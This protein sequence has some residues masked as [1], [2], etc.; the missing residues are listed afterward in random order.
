ML[1][2]ALVAYGVPNDVAANIL[3]GID[4]SYGSHAIRNKINRF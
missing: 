3:V 1:V 4:L 2:D